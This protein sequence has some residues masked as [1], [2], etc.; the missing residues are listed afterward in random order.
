VQSVGV[1]ISELLPLPIGV[2]AGVALY[3]DVRALGVELGANA[4]WLFA[5]ASG[6]AFGLVLV[7]VRR[8][9]RRAVAGVIG[10][11]DAAT[12]RARDGYTYLAFLLLWAGA[13]GVRLSVPH[14]QVLLCVFA[15]AQSWAV[16]SALSKAPSSAPS[17]A[18]APDR[19][20]FFDSNAWLAI[21]FLVSGMAALI[22][23]IVWQRVLFSIYGVNIE[24]VT[25]V[26]AVF[27]LGLG[28]GALAGGVL[29]RR[30]PN[31]APLLF[32]ACEIGIAAF[33]AI[34]L[35][36]IHAVGER[37]HHLPLGGVA[38][39]LFGLLLVPV[40][41]MGAT[42]PLLV[43][44]LARHQPNIGASLGR[45]YALNTLG[46]ALASVLTVDVL[47]AYLGRQATVF[48]AVALNVMV[49][50]LVYRYATRVAA[51]PPV[52]RP[53]PPSRAHP[54]L[55]RWATL[56]LAFVTGFISLSQEIVWMRPV[57]FATQGAAHV[58]GHVLGAF[59]I[60]VA[61]GAWK[62]KRVCEAGLHDPVRYLGFRLVLAGG[63]Y[64]L[65]LP[66]FS[67]AMVVNKALG[68][69]IAYFL[70]G[71]VAYL[72]GV[73]LPLLAQIGARN[74]ESAGGGVALIYAANVAGATAGPL[75][76]GFV[77]LDR[78]TLQECVLSVSLV[79]VVIG[80]SLYARRGI[81]KRAALAFAAAAT[82]CV[83]S[84]GRLYDHV[85]AKLKFGPQYYEQ[86]VFAHM[87]Q[88]RSGV[89]AVEHHPEGDIVY[90]GGSYDG[91]F[92][93]GPVNNENGIW[94]AYMVGALHPKPQ[95]VLVIGLSSGSWTW[96]L[97]A[98]EAV[99]HIT[100][101]DI[102]PG[103]QELIRAYPSHRDIL[104]HPKITFYRDDG[105]RWLVRHREE[106]F[107][108]V[109]MNTTFHWR[110]NITSLLSREF[111]ELCKSR[112]EPNGVL[113]Y[114][115]TGSPDV[116]RTA[117]AVFP[118]VTSYGSFVA[119]SDG[120]FEMDADKRRENLRAFR[121]GGRSLFDDDPRAHA[122]LDTLVSTPLVEQGEALRKRGDL[123]IITDD[124]MLPEFKRI[125]SDEL[126]G[127]LYRRRGPSWG[128]VL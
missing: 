64:Y 128:E 3:F 12:Y 1:R 97:A 83:L 93:V 73:V 23:E 20:P 82:A 119:A 42:L 26:V 102:N 43:Q 36:L 7:L 118:H 99:E 76:T 28:L 48:T 51:R 105:R 75:L 45:L 72:M 74:D 65:A 96:V 9:L 121:D 47:F 49:A 41:L 54:R 56:L 85:F 101:V 120:P 63:V 52:A 117:A 80:L 125:H 67:H 68:I 19:P 5:A 58:F 22:Y 98:H 113:Y 91:R 70:V 62:A 33:G 95:R 89:I 32:A 114:N 77:L 106:R 104:E 107:D 87:I 60:G 30:F 110:G 126:I 71:L 25:L 66:A 86:R 53:L 108:V 15:I 17:S 38:V 31:R 16:L 8:G 59:L 111:L 112:L 122:V 2:L 100:V 78:L 103:Y 55:P 88:N 11:S 123:E 4:P 127:K 46:A 18:S 21:L 61:A 69:P 116:A 40:L 109:V 92:N 14:V 24:S 29:S 10:P 115:A 39:V 94:R 6:V 44:H 35:P 50:A 90:G 34:S 27:M 79:T 13:F 124:N 81:D 84:Y 37:T 57:S